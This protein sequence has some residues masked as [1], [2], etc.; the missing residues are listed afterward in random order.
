M[1]ISAI[2]LMNLG[3]AA[4]LAALLAAVMLAPTRLHRPF[5]TGHTHRQKAALR[6]QLWAQRSRRQHAQRSAQPGLRPISD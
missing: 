1:S 6:R 4:I 3:A 2:I 5:A